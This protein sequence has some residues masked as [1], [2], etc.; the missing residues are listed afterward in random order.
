MLKTSPAVFAVEN[1]Y[2]IM[3]QTNSPC[4][5]WVRVDGE[6][7]YD[8]S[9]GIMRSLSDLHR[10]IVPMSAL[11][12]A[13]AYTVCVRPLIERKP[14]FS[15]TAP[16]EEYNFTFTPVPDGAV[17]AYHIAD[18]HNRVEEPIAAARAFGEIDLL[19][20]NGDV[21]NHS[22]DPEKFDVVYEICSR[23]TGGTKPVVFSRG[24]HDMRGNFAERFAEYTPNANGKTYYTVRLGSLWMILLDCGEDKTDDHAEYGYTVCC[25]AFRLRQT[26]FLKQVIADGEYADESI[27]T[28]LLICHNPFTRQDVPPFNIEAP[29]YR[30]WGVLL[31]DHIRPDAMICG[32]VH[33]LGVHYVGGEWD[34]LGQP[35]TM[36][37]GS[38]PDEGYFAGCG[39]VFDGK[40]I[41]VTFTDSRGEIL[42]TTLF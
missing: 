28:R 5:F 27:R 23:L 36:V 31:K 4:L 16:V 39:Y 11:D 30:E 24:N 9:N 22:G 34:H 32:H 38:K 15:Q 12:R 18:A 26:A 40:N 21:I 41:A 33:E 29:I 25:H 8:E 17:R 13:K 1:T 37:T 20:L 2:Q 6:E 3:V 10:V 19:I 14:Y 7:Y 35:C 42:G